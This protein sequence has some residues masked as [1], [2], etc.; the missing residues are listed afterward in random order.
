MVKDQNVDTM[1]QMTVPMNGK[2]F[3]DMT[4]TGSYMVKGG[5]GGGKFDDMSS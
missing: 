2:Q 5:G 4:S 3:D 1:S